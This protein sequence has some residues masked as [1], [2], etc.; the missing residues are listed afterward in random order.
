MLSLKSPFGLSK[1]SCGGDALSESSSSLPASYADDEDQDENSEEFQSSLTT[2]MEG[3][4]CNGDAPDAPS[5][6][7]C[8]DP[9][10][11]S[12]SNA[13]PPAVDDADSAGD[14]LVSSAINFYTGSEDKLLAAW[15]LR[16][17]AKPLAKKHVRASTLLMTFEPR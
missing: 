13:L 4:A 5:R 16:N 2:S 14:N 7:P 10:P 8:S 15:D 3:V 6:K 9:S 1:R 12:A 17:I 11:P